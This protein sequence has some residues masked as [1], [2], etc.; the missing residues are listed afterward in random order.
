MNKSFKNFHTHKSVLESWGDYYIEYWLDP[1]GKM[2]RATEGHWQ[3]VAASGL[4]HMPDKLWNDRQYVYMSMAKKGY[5]RVTILQPR[6]IFYQKYFTALGENF[7]A[8]LT[9]T[10]R[11]VLNQ[12]GRKREKD[13]TGVGDGLHDHPSDVLYTHTK[14]E[15]D[16]NE[17]VVTGIVEPIE[18]DGLGILKAKIDSGNDGYNVIHGINVS[19]FKQNNKVIIKFNTADNKTVSFPQQGW[20]EVVAGGKTHQRPVILINFKYKNQS[21]QN[22]PFSVADRSQNEEKV[23]LGVPFLKRINAVIDVNRSKVVA[24][25]TEMDRIKCNAELAREISQLNG[26]RTKIEAEINYYIEVLPDPVPPSLYIELEDVIKKIEDKKS[27]IMPSSAE[28]LARIRD[29]QKGLE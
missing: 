16:V 2:I 14:P 8:Q 23:L 27:R 21:F 13:V 26:I 15:E 19:R 20:V 11:A 10:Q 9:P 12:E 28:S 25:M 24:E 29:I 6:D 18:I 17:N 7:T 5:V 4:L 22:E 3:W 1:S